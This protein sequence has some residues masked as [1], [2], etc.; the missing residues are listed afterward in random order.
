MRSCIQSGRKNKNARAA[1]KTCIF[2]AGAAALRGHCRRG[3]AVFTGHQPVRCP[4]RAVYGR[5]YGLCAAA[6]H[7]VPAS[8]RAGAEDRHCR[9]HQ[10]CNQPSD[11]MHRVE[12]ARPS[13]GVQNAAVRH[14]DDCFYVPDPAHGHSARR[15]A[16]RMSHRR[17]S[18]RLRHRHHALDGRHD[19]RHGRDR[20]D[21]H[22]KGLA[23]VHR[24]CEPVLE[25]GALCDL[26]RRV[27]PV[28]GDLFDPVFVH[29]H[30]GDGQAAHAEHQRR[31]HG[32][33]EGPE[34]GDGAR[35]SRRPP[36]RHYAL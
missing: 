22:Q 27:Q 35:N 23:Y 36:P 4:D 11:F 10:L 34:P 1:A 26:R 16:G 19:G 17:H 5:N 9:Y 7:A 8:D 20:H 29:L 3:A 32:R 30:D 25:H 13:R 6:A 33:D 14:V 12:T 2:K 24:P 31:G 15:S 28:H 21:A 18:L